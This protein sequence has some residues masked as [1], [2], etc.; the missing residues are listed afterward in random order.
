MPTLSYYSNDSKQKPDN[1]F[2]S[3]QDHAT[4]FRCLA[5]ASV[6]SFR[7]GVPEP[8]FTWMSPEASL[9]AWMPAIHAGM[10]DVVP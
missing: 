5:F 6:S 2:H 4:V 1:V 9:R 10:T 3:V 8:R 7:H